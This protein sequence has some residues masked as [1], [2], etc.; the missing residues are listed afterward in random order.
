MRPRFTLGHRQRI[1]HIGVT[2]PKSFRI[3]AKHFAMRFSGQR[4][5][6]KERHSKARATISIANKR[7]LK[8]Y[9]GRERRAQPAARASVGAAPRRASFV[10]LGKTMKPWWPRKVIKPALDKNSWSIVWDPLGLAT[11][12]EAVVS[13]LDLES[14]AKAQ[15][16]DIVQLRLGEDGEFPVIDLGFYGSPPRFVVRF[17]VDADWDDEKAAS[18]H[19]SFRE[20]LRAVQSSI[21]ATEP[22]SHWNDDEKEP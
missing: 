13:D 6:S 20:A 17:Q 7:W 15:G 14:Q 18:Y 8:L 16:E 9:L 22:W 4:M 1:S 2:P 12:K 21:D 19:D 5:P 3:G 11:A 10:T